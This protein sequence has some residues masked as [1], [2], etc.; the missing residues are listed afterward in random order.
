M[1]Q[2]RYV[3]KKEFTCISRDFSLHIQRGPVA[4]PQPIV[5]PQLR[6]SV[7]DVSRALDSLATCAAGQGNL[8][9]IT[10]HFG[11]DRNGA[12]DLVLQ[13][14]CMFPVNGTADTYTYTPTA[15]YYVIVGGHLVRAPDA[16]TNWLADS[17][18]R[19]T[20]EVVKRRT[21][22]PTWEPFRSGV[23]VTSITFLYEGELDLLI[24]ENGLT[25][26]DV[27][28]LVPAAE[29]AT[30][31]DDG[32]GGIE[33]NDFYQ[34][35]CWVGVGVELDDVD[36]TEKFKNKG[37]DLGSLCPPNCASLYLPDRGQPRRPGC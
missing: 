31:K 37:A 7:D 8:R 26:T 4:S 11:L 22:G 16:I 5:V 28:E 24:A 19:Y 2:F 27:L 20:K 3:P 36:H 10:V 25:E 13:F 29:P 17:G 32:H 18:D 30:W 1:T 21:D 33:E 9:G 23:D 34:S 35:L 14:V 12:L 15:T 6:F